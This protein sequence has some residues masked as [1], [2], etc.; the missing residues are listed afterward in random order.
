MILKRVIQTAD[1]RSGHLPDFTGAT[2]HRAMRRLCLPE[3]KAL[4]AE[5]LIG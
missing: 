2:R 1:E 3:K 4:V 5:H